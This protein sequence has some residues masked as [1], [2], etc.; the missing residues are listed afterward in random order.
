MTTLNQISSP[1]QANAEVVI[2]E[3]LETLEHQGVYGKNHPTTSGLTWG[4]YGGRWSGYAITAATLALTDASAN[5]LVVARASGVISTSTAA[6]NW[7]DALNY[8]RVYKLTTAGGV[9]TAVEDHRAGR[10]GV[11]GT[12]VVVGTVTLNGVDG[13]T[14]THNQ[15]H[16][17]YVLTVLPTGAN[18]QDVGEISYVKAANTVV[19]Y[20][21]GQ[22]R[23]AADYELTASG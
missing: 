10:N 5:Y 23:L 9:V 2:N 20:N 6:T 8:A 16:T 3:N 4:Y 12:V 13:V 15:G 1:P 18:A 7:N 11:H 14:I 17:N 22:P 21:T 19:V